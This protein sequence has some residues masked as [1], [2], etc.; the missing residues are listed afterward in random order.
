MA[1]LLNQRRFCSQRT[2]GDVWTRVWLVQRV[3]EMGDRD[4]DKSPETRRTALHN[5]GL[6]APRCPQGHCGETP[7]EAK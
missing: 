3:G 1:V 7:F 4:A 5:K 6:P 2:F